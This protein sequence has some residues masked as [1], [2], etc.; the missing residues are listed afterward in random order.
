MQTKHICYRKFVLKSTIA[1]S[2]TLL[3]PRFAENFHIELFGSE[4][5]DFAS[6]A[7]ST[8]EYGSFARLQFWGFFAMQKSDTIRGEA[9]HG[10]DN[11]KQSCA[12]CARPCSAA[13]KIPPKLKTSC[14]ARLGHRRHWLRI[15][16]IYKRNQ[17]EH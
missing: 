16:Q 17:Y 4:S 3:S 9:R 15:F 2:K 11:P 10:G 12:E 14:R 6:P 5:F 8:T 1:T 7:Q 13:G